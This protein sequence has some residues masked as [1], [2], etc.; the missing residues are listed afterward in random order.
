MSTGKFPRVTRRRF[1]EQTGL[2]LL[3]AGSAPALSAPFV[4]PALA[5]T[6]SLSIVQWSHFVP[7]YD[8]WFDKFAL[9]WGEKN[10]IAVTVDH[11]PVQDIAAR[12]AAEASAG[13]GHDL[14]GWNGAGGAHLYRKFLVDVTSLVEDAEKKHGKVTV[15]GKQ[16]AYNQDDHSW[17]AFPDFY[18]N[19][20]VMYRKSLWASIGVQPDSW[21]NIRIGGAKLK[22]K[23]NPV[24]ISLGHSN[25]PNTTWRGLLW[26]FGGAVQDETGKH[27]VLNSKESVEAV[28]Y[29]AALY[30]E[31]MTPDVLSWNDASNNQYIVSGVASLIINPI[32]AYRTCQQA[33][34]KVADDIFVLRPPKG[35]ARQFMGGA[36]EFYGIWKF[37]KNQDA[38]KDFLRYYA[39]NWIGAFKASEGYNMPIFSSIVPKPMPLLSDDPT[40]NPHDKLAIL[41]TSDEWSA[42]PGYPGPA[43]PATDEVYNNFIICDMMAKAAT[44]AMTPEES[45]KWASQQCEGIFEKW[46][47]KA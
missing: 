17:S 22:A 23:G 6:K 19:F 45:V 7:A 44:G 5:D 28:K 39:D 31:A 20:P 13:S 40:S 21:D 8:K 32:S 10:K 3:A 24:G 33:N 9:N 25:D 36:A 34:K 14:F 41:Q 47:H 15:I 35:P 38:A 30:K 12:A 18:I 11:I 16:I 1:L 27:V 42:V 46:L 26:S 37:A 2:T 43:W 29:V 4:S